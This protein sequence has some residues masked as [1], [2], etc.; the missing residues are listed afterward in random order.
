[1]KILYVGDIMGDM[2]IR[3]VEQVLPKLRRDT[4]ATVMIAHVF[5]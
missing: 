4:H 3:V 5:P 1:M 2:G